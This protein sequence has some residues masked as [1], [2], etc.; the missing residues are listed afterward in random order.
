MFRRVVASLALAFAFSGAIVSSALAQ[1]HI[2]AADLDGD[3]D[4]DS[5]EEQGV[6]TASPAGN[7]CSIESV[8]CTTGAGTP[9]ALVVSSS[10]GVIANDDRINGGPFVV[11]NVSV[12]E[13]TGGLTSIGVTVTF[14]SS[15]FAREISLA[16]FSSTATEGLDFQ[17]PAGGTLAPGFTSMT[18]TVEIVAD[19]EPEL[20]ETFQFTV[21]DTADVASTTSWGQVR[22]IDDDTSLPPAGIAIGR[23][24]VVE[25]NSGGAVL[26]FPVTVSPASE[27]TVTVDFSSS[28]GTAIG[29][30]DYTPVTGTLRFDPGITTQTIL[31]PVLGDLLV[32]ADETVTV[33]LSNVTAG[34]PPTC[35]FDA[36]RA[37]HPDGTG[38]SFCSPHNCFL[39]SGIGGVIVEPPSVPPNNDGPRD[40]AGNCLGALRIFS[41]TFSRCRMAGTQT[42][43][44]NCC[45]NRGEAMNDTMGESGGSTQQSGVIAAIGGASAAMVS[46]GP[47]A[48]SSVLTGAFDPTTLVAAVAIYALTEMLNER[49]DSNDMQTALLKDSGYCIDIGEYCSEEWPLVG[50]VQRAHGHCCFNSMLAR[51]INE[52]GRAQ[53]PSMGGFGTPEEPNCRGFTPEE[54]QAI[55]FSKVDLSDYFAEVRT[56]TQSLIE[57]EIRPRITSEIRGGQ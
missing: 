56:K 25:G 12:V 39:R 29:G 20:D 54:F 47:A 2:C 16:G 53:I 27:D 42:H 35:P 34:G 32:E 5:Q 40:A 17:M 49:C 3:G 21:W 48:A 18:F 9:P 41:G 23:A 45:R 33:T 10:L 38:Q 19:A 37:C 4:A 50:C 6:C 57:G 28:D 22:I 1:E 7:L 15:P 31:V 26:S 13:R 24:T 52:Q 36:A 55:D 14:P 43:F 44:S 8:P 11:S 46:G 51:I 30:S